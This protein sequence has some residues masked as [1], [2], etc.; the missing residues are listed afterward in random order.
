MNEETLQTWV[1]KHRTVDDV[2]DARQANLMCATMDRQAEMAPGMSLPPLWHWIYFA[3]ARPTSGIGPDGHAALGDFMPPIDQQP[4]GLSR[5][6][7]AG[8]RVWFHHPIEI[9]AKAS[10]KLT[11]KSITPKQGRSGR[12]C[13]LTLLHEISVDGQVCLAEEKDIVYLEPQDRNSPNRNSPDRNGQAKQLS[14]PPTGAT[15]MRTISP[16]S[17][18]LFRYSA[19]MFN[20]HRIHYDVDFCRDV[21][22]YP[23]L[24]VHGPL[25][26]TLLAGL[27]AEQSGSLKTFTYRAVSP[28]FNGSDFSIHGRPAEGKNQSVK[29]GGSVWV[30][31]C[32][33]DQAMQADYTTA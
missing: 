2:I 15:I 24:L 32:N 7:W 13:F 31:T 3:E 16:N 22:G 14:A 21:E 20:G 30:E 28:I 11:I 17:T 29:G 4:Y 18:W 19:L 26:A 5:R 8:G 9:G 12:M 10:K 33:G 27:A 23:D 1:G 6:M 25:L